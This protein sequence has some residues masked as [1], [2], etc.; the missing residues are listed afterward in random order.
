[1]TVTVMTSF[2]LVHRMVTDHPGTVLG[3]VQDYYYI[4]LAMDRS[5]G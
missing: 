5:K 3:M 4:S 2:E 1:M